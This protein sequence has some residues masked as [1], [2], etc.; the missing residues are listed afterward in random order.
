MRFRLAELATELEALRSL[1]YR[2]TGLYVA[3]EDGKG[4]ERARVRLRAAK[5][6]PPPPLVVELGTGYALRVP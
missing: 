6:P 5:G 3:G 4:T 1:L 2:A